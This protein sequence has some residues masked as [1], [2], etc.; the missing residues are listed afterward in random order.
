MGEE[1]Q[2]KVPQ[3]F[4]IQNNEF[5]NPP[6]LFIPLLEFVRK[7][8][9]TKGTSKTEKSDLEFLNKIYPRLKKWYNWFNTTQGRKLVFV[10]N[11][12]SLFNL[13][14]L[15]NYRLHI[16]GVDAILIRLLN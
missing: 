14:K 8:N 4:W 3:E 9:S 16:V 12:C 5:A 11:E 2:A 7:V 10:N 6:T 13:F 15:V 1:A